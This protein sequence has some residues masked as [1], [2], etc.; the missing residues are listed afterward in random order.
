MLAAIA[1]FVGSIIGAGI[2]GIPF[3]V[4]QTGFGI[5][6]IL[7]IS[8]TTATTILS[9]MLAELTLRTKKDHQ[10]PGYSALYLGPR[11]GSITFFIDIIS[12]YIVQLAY[13]VGLGEVLAALLSGSPV[14]WSVVVFCI[15]AVFVYKGLETIKVIELVMTIGIFVIV[16]ILAIILSPHISL[17]NFNYAD[18]TRVGLPY[19]VIMFALA[20][21]ITIPAIRR[22]LV[23][24]E[25]KFPSVIIISYILVFIVYA[26]F[27]YIVL[28]VTGHET[29]E[30][31]TIG[32][33][34]KIGPVMIVL[35]NVLALFTMSTCYLANGLAL[36]RVFEFDYKKPR[37]LSTFLAVIPALILF[38]F[39][40]R[41]FI[42]ILGLVGGIILGLQSAFI[43]LC[44]WKA[45]KHGDRKPEFRLGKLTLVGLALL[46]IYIIGAILTLLE[47]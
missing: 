29:T 39:G 30:V 43:I 10:M 40:I 2:L 4:A 34:M 8:L 24:N 18:P 42:I 35:G 25:K 17:L 44:F 15:V 13:I 23:G 6:I 41:H 21:H 46:T 9:L 47:S 1:T 22:L 32:L 33:G 14:F 16:L 12:G 3:A 36:R 7:L 5:G 11:F 37:I 28:G 19:G 27:M 45:Q 31:A 38:V 20:G 26:T